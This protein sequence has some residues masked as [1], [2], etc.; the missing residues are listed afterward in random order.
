MSGKK[1][2]PMIEIRFF[3]EKETGGCEGRF[4]SVASGRFQCLVALGK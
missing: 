4:N 3:K 1:K 2:P